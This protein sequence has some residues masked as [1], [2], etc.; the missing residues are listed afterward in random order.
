M[1]KI[2]ALIGMIA[3]VVVLLAIGPLAVI[4]AWNTLFPAVV[5][6]FSFWTWLAVV[7]LGA[8]FRANVSIKKD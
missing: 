2:V 8:F 1:T 7:I 6:Q 4:W 5:V 3:F